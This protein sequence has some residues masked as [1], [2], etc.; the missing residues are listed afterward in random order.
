MPSGPMFAFHTETVDMKNYIILGLV[1]TTL[2]I[3]ACNRRGRV[4]MNAMRPAMITVPSEIQNIVLLDRSHLSD[5]KKLNILEGILTGEL[6]EEDKAAV[7]RALSRLNNEIQN[8]PRFTGVLASER[9]EGNSLTAAFPPQLDWNTIE[10]LCRKYKAQAVLSIEIFDTDF[11]PTSGKR[12]TTKTV[13]EG[14]KKREVQV[15]EW[16]AKGVANLTMGVRFY[17][18]VNKQVIDEQFYRRTNTWEAAAGSKSEAIA[19]LITKGDASANLSA[20]I[21]ADYARRIAPMPIRVHRM[22]YRKH[23]K[24]P[25]IAM[26]ARM[27]DVNRWS[28]A[29]EA[30]KQGLPIAD[31]KR[32]GWLTYNIAVAHEVLG[33]LDE[34]LRWAQD[35][36]IKYGNRDAQN[37]VQTIQ[38]RKLDEERLKEQQ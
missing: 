21:G 31:T 27:A 23:K 15:D 8:T 38:N 32:A 16:Y 9:L 34:A 18:F 36:Y 20:A 12:V 30:W 5:K 28:D 14:D 4:S 33:D 3:G 2:T 17:D 24:A 19:K 29:I 10:G 25:A 37:Y 26:G 7:Q 11:I 13:G 6:P 22:F 35:A 1:L